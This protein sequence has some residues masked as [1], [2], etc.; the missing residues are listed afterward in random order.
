MNS[1]KPYHLISTILYEVQPWRLD[2]FMK[3]IKRL[4]YELDLLV[5]GLSPL[6]YQVPIQLKNSGLQISWKLWALTIIWLTF[7]SVF[8][9]NECGSIWIILSLFVA[10][11]MN[12]GERK[13]G[14]LSAYSVFNTG[15]Q[16]LLG[17]MTAE[18][19]E[20][21]IRHEGLKNSNNN[22]NGNNTNEE[23]SSAVSEERSSKSDGPKLRKRGKKARRNYEDK[24]KRRELERATQE[25]AYS[26]DLEDDFGDEQDF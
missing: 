18:Q 26:S 6:F 25:Q 14:E 16:R 10:I 5:R 20:S 8:N 2:D 9:Y 13:E 15:C 17:T 1:S 4:V 21:E 23:N 7:F 19:F 22:N 24:L 3:V 11:F 12:L